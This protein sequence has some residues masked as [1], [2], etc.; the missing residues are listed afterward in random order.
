M[1]EGPVQDLIDELGRLPGIGPK[2]AQRIAFHLL[3]AEP[4]DVTRLQ[5]VLQKVKEGVVFCDV[6]GNVSEETTCRICRDVRR[7]KA[8]VC[9]VEEPKDV[10]AVERT[11]EF[12]GRYHVLGGALDPLSGVGPDQLRVRELL[13]RIGKDDITE[14]I[15]ATDP[16]TEGEATATYLVRMLRDFPGLTVTRLASGLPMGGD[17][18]F[19]D[20]LTLGRAL[21]GRRAL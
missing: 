12:K 10:L 21:S 6:C 1:Y 20:E 16:N 18:E 7:D 9:V 14:V 2:S 8:L 13:A 11:R 3:A 19:A 17:L 5:E 15:I 4:A